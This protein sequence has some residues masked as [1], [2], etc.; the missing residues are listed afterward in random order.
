MKKPRCGAT[1]R[2]GT[3]CQA[4]A[5]WSTRS[6]RYTRCRNHG[7]LST[8][9]KTAEGIERIRQAVRKFWRFAQ[10]GNSDKWT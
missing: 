4:S 9:P 2:R 3:A 6:Q 7:G 8:G 1:T 10:S 5:I